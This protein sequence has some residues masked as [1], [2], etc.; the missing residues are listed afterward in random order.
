MWIKTQNDQ[1]NSTV[2][3]TNNVMGFGI[4]R[5]GGDVYNVFVYGIGGGYSELTEFVEPAQLPIFSGSKSECEK[6]FDELCKIITVGDLS[7][8]II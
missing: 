8:I 3:N 2:I 5:I 6:F 1:M 7:H 4:D